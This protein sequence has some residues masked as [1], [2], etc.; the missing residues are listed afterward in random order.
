MF[1]SAAAFKKYALMLAV[2]LP[3]AVFVFLRPAAA[4]DAAWVQIEAQPSLATAEERA[5]SYAATLP[6]V[7][8]FSLG[9]GWY[10]VALGPY[11]PD[12]AQDILASLRRDGLIPRDSFI[13]FAA[14]FQQQFWPIGANLL[15]VTPLAPALEQTAEPAIEPAPE[16][17]IAASDETP[18]EA[19]A[20]EGRL[21]RDERKDLQTLLQWAGFYQGRIDGAFGRGTR[22]SMAAWQEANGYEP[23]G[24]L[25]TLQRTALL[26]AYNAILDGLGMQVMTDA[27]AGISMM[28]P[29]EVVAFDRYES[30]FAHY[31]PTGS[32]PE[33]KL[34]LISQEGDQNTLFGLYDIMQT[35]EIVPLDGER[36]RG[37]NSFS[38][39]GTNDSFISQSE[40][41]LKNGRVKGF[42]LIWPTGDEER[43]RRIISEMQNSF[44]VTEAVLDPTAGMDQEQ[45]IDLVSGLA[46]RTP[47]LSRSGFYV[48]PNGTV[49]TSA[50]AVESCQRITVDGDFDASVV[51]VDAGTGLALLRPVEALSPVS[52]AAFQSQLP[53][54]H[55]DI[56]VAGYPFEGA[57]NAPTLT[58]GKLSDTRGLG[59]EQNLFRIDSDTLS[60]D[61]G[62]PI[63]DSTGAVIGILAP[64]DLQGRALPKGVGFGVRSSAM[65]A[66]LNDAGISPI[67]TLSR[68][69]IA[70]EDLSLVAADM[71]VLVSCWD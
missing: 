3:L 46:I 31:E 35:L 27:D 11:S 62:G 9:G 55:A 23:T 48:A 30:P 59:G 37:S 29:T 20:S 61:V 65:G 10:A 66:I 4:Q 54:L 14:S 33:A 7:N 12:D 18:R 17:Q 69:S 71:T 28:V 32:I 57:L 8:G 58:F 22:G 56:A 16:P 67:Q 19:R 38:L 47:R 41:S 40:V 45:Q 63:M 2:F 43:R 6:A 21:N 70:A 52:I 68:N 39:I 51:S 1:Q 15:N 26:Q 25:T 49:L 13:A 53:R 36:T 50:D 42:T 5:R 24:I 64:L 60:G 34:L 44:A